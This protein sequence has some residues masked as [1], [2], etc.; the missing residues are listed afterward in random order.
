MQE[1]NPAYVRKQIQH[2]QEINQVV[3]KTNSQIL[4]QFF[5]IAPNYYLG[6]I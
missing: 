2:M 3:S 4:G 6:N 1:I 5:K